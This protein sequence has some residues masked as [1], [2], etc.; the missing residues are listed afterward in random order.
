MRE[1]WHKVG[2]DFVA[3]ARDLVRRDVTTVR[4]LGAIGAKSPRS[5]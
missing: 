4:Q 2:E 1:G 5:C 3:V